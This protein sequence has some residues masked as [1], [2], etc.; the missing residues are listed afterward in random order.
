M[1][2][3]QFIS[4][5]DGINVASKT[6]R[7]H[8]SLVQIRDALMV[9]NVE[10]MPF[11]E[12]K[13]LRRGIIYLS[14]IDDSRDYSPYYYI[15][16][17]ISEHFNG[18]TERIADWGEQVWKDVIAYCKSLPEYPHSNA[19]SHEWWTRERNRARAA[20]L[21]R[22]MGAKVSVKDCDLSIEDLDGVYH[23]IETLM[24]EI[25]G[26]YALN[27][28]IKDLPYRKDIGRFLVPHQGNRPMS[29]MI[30]LE[31]PYGFLF[32]L[33]AEYL[34]DSGSTE[35]IAEKWKEVVDIAS[36]LC[37]AIYDLQKYDIWS[38][39]IYKKE[40]VVKV[41]H[42]MVL[43]FSVY[44]L[45]Q[46]NVSFALDWCR[47]L[48][49]QM[50]RVVRCDAVLRDKLERVERMMNW[51]MMTSRPDVC[52]NIKKGSKEAKVLEQNM[53]DLEPEI[54]I[55]FDKVNVGFVRPNDM[56]KVNVMRYPVVMTAD[57]YILLPRAL[58]VWNWYEAVFNIIKPNKVLAK[59]IGFVME[60]F[61]RNKM[62][63]HGIV[64]HTGNYTYK[65]KAMDDAVGEVD[66]L[67]ESGSMDVIIE[68]KKKSLSQHSRSGD[69][70]YIW[71]DLYEM[72]Y[73]QMQCARL[74]NAVKKY[75]T[76]VLDDKRTGS[77][78]TYIWRDTE[79]GKKRWV[80]KVAMTMKEY[81]PM[82]DKVVLDSM[83][84]NIIGGNVKVAFEPT[85]MS[86]TAN[87]QASILET[88]RKL[89][90]ALDSWTTYVT[91][92]GDE[93]TTIFCRFYSMEQVYFLIKQSKGHDDF[94]HLIGGINATTGTENFWNEYV[95]FTSKGY[96]ELTK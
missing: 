18:A 65:N 83:I 2:T 14:E 68:S 13:R 56:D 64:S 95:N 38:D 93:K 55:E 27:L 30:E 16:E 91:E 81:G 70:Y 19:F 49:K 59:D 22:P 36:N 87:D 42:E 29:S 21:L 44:T 96:C 17:K 54:L 34:K 78:Y 75:G 43:R 92:M 76:V 23:R 77:S 51:A 82:Q 85:D 35:G 28:L 25:G 74:E 33:C 66:F 73:A 80:V 46:T 24:T 39:I 57:S 26:M 67:I 69:D 52:V 1:D 4:L 40:E 60:D 3:T 47:F 61:I 63:T 41:I 72:I 37:L 90:K 8:D 6:A 88:I 11:A 94:A 71:G 48:I 10:G 31:I 58:C 45:P 9:K 84:R 12:F 32:N 86:H 89:N 50:K 15:L 20:K 7:P 62:Q 53:S 79:N 5:C